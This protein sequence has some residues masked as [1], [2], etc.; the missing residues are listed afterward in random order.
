MTISLETNLPTVKISV[1]ESSFVMR[2]CFILSSINYN[3]GKFRAT[4]GRPFEFFSLNFDP[5]S[6][7]SSVPENFEDRLASSN[8][9]F[10]NSFISLL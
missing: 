2:F 1:F 4:K 7:N 8:A 10:G 5:T 3:M 6:A 9:I